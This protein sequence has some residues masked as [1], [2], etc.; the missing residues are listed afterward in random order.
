MKNSIQLILTFLILNG[1]LLGSDSLKIENKRAIQFK[2]SDNIIS[3]SNDGIMISL[4]RKINAK[5]GIRYGLGLNGSMNDKKTDNIIIGKTDYNIYDYHFSLFSQYVLSGF[6][7]RKMKPYFGIGPYLGYGYNFN[8]KI[9]ELYNGTE[10]ERV[11]EPEVTVGLLSNIGIEIFIF[12]NLSLDIEYNIL[13]NYIY[14]RTTNTTLVRNTTDSKYVKV[15][16]EIVTERIYKLEPIFS[17]IGICLY[18]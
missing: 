6:K 5:H 10:I 9:R 13:M 12:D 14:C 16:E 2:F 7:N 3:S 18:Y 11:K 8:E 4:K 1:I 15:S 17:L